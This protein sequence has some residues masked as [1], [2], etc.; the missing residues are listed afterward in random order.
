M[1]RGDSAG[2][3]VDEWLKGEDGETAVY[4]EWSEEKEQEM[5]MLEEKLRKAQMGWSDE[6]EEILGPVSWPGL[7]FI[8]TAFVLL[9]LPQV[10]SGYWGYY[11]TQFVTSN[12]SFSALS[13]MLL[14]FRCFIFQGTILICL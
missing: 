1:S 11:L 5:L 10:L 6:Q 8:F 7:F 14:L 9:S 4:E 2:T 3:T 13:V 12:M